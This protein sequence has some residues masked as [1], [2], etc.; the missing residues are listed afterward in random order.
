ME[1]QCC[2]IEIK[3]DNFIKCNKEPCNAII[4]LSC[5]DKYV[6]DMGKVDCMF[7]N[8]MEQSILEITNEEGLIIE[9][10]SPLHSRNRR[11]ILYYYDLLFKSMKIYLV[12]TIIFKFFGTCACFYMTSDLCSE[13]FYFQEI[14][15][16]WNWI[17]GY[18]L[19]LVCCKKF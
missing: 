14:S 17:P 16:M 15:Y 13:S 6:N 18:A 19:F 9:H 3:G 10:N 11:Q 7:C 8:P 4:C 5:Y 12:G 1:C 2:F